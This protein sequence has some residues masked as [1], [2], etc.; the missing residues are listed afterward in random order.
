[1]KTVLLVAL[2]VSL[3]CSIRISAKRV[4]KKKDF[5]ADDPCVH[6]VFEV[7]TLHLVNPCPPMPCPTVVYHH[8]VMAAPMVVYHRPVMTP[9]L[10]YPMVHQVYSPV[11][12]LGTLAPVDYYNPASHIGSPFIYRRLKKQAAKEALRKS[13]KHNKMKK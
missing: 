7:P 5:I 9:V 1:M 13:R 10:T 8:P 4:H 12:A 11:S 6:H 3:C 2:C